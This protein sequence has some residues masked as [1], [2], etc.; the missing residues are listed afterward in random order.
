MKKKP[1]ALLLAILCIGILERGM[2]GLAAQEHKTF[3]VSEYV[4]E[5]PEG[6]NW[7]QPD[8]FMRKAQLEVP[9]PS[10]SN[11]AEVV[12][13]YFGPGD[14]G[15]TQANIDRWLRQFEEPREQ[16]KAKIEGQTIAGVKVYY[17]QAEGTYLQGK[18]GQPKKPVPNQA[19]Y[20]CIIEGK[21]GHVFIRMT[22]DKNLVKK[23]ETAK[24][25]REMIEKAVK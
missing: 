8:S 18:P 5:R 23:E 24:T 15:G 1:F 20:G 19:L 17:V 25:F 16:L 13:F 3:K 10:G 7:I 14:A 21:A 12:F 6:W 11:P 22:G 4:F 9:H 2:A